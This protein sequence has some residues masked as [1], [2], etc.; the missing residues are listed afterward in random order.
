MSTTKQITFSRNKI[1]A[2]FLNP[3]V[4][5]VFKRDDCKFSLI[6]NSKRISRSAGVIVELHGIKDDIR[7]R[8]VP[9]K[10]LYIYGYKFIE[11]KIGDIL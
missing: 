6:V 9:A 2:A 5:D 10:H 1:P 7:K 4:G 8:T 3:K 11:N